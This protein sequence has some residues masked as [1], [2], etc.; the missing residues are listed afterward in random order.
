MSGSSGAIV[1]APN[2]RLIDAIQQFFGGSQATWNSITIPIP[3]GLV[4]YAVDTTALKIGDG[5]T[6]YSDLPVVITLDAII[7]AASGG[8]SGGISEST[9]ASYVTAALSSYV[10]SASF[11]TFTSNYL[12]NA[13]L[14]G[15]PTAPTQSSADNSTKIATTAYVTT[16]IAAAVLAA[17]G[18][19]VTL[20]AMNA[21]ISTAITAALS[22]SPALGGS[23]IA[24]TAS[25]GDTTTRVATTQ[26]VSAAINL[27]TTTL[28]TNYTTTA[29]LNTLLTGY[30]STVALNTRLASYATTT[31]LNNIFSRI[32]YTGSFDLF[33]AT[34]GTDRPISDRS[35]TYTQPFLTIQSALDW[36]SHNLDL[37]GNPITIHVGAGT[38]N[39]NISV[40]QQIPGQNDPIT[41]SGI[42]VGTVISSSGGSPVAVIAATSGASL[43]IQNVLITSIQA[44]VSGIAASSGGSIDVGTGVT[45]GAMS[46]TG[47]HI[48]AFTGGTVYLNTSYSINGAMKAHITSLYGG[49]VVVGQTPT[50]TIIS[51]AGAIFTSFISCGDGGVVAMYNWGYLITTRSHCCWKEI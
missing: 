8:G 25:P 24:T 12:N 1:G 16:A 51:I 28:T 15:N 9:M 37:Q 34:T 40:N 7:A 21:A 44:G 11:S 41:I 38:F 23:P 50:S 43:R 18:G 47:N 29:A 36:A 22:G 5:S 26:F 48:L 30:V 3:A 6:L 20:G 2:L 19:G 45:F 32:A 39:G 33:V 13:A 42:G 17:A 46:S 49:V 14:T 10:T 31:A 35:T 4:V 27:V